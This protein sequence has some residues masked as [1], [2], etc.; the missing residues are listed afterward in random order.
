MIFIFIS[1]L[2]LISIF[3]IIISINP[4]Y[5][6]IFLVAYFLLVN[7]L[8]LLLNLDFLALMMII[9]YAGAIAILFLFV[10]M[11][12]NVKIIETSFF[13]L[14]K[15]LPLGILLIILFFLQMLFII[16]NII[17]EK[18]FFEVTT[19]HY[20]YNYFEHYNFISNVKTLGFL[21]YNDFWFFFLI[22]SLILLL[23]MLGAIALTMQK[24]KFL[25]QQIYIQIIRNPSTSIL[26]K[27]FR[28][29]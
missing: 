3:F 26:L 13:N 9:I 10:I 16:I 21:I 8:F 17:E 4:V 28:N 14:K 29:K 23:A 11:M 27:K 24:K 15:Q 2:I 6:L 20:N 22:A 1:I 5:S 12:L 19:I 18:P 25:R 7:C